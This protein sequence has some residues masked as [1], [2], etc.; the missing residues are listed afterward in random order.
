MRLQLPEK[1]VSKLLSLPESGMGYQN[2]TVTFVDG[3]FLDT[4]VMNGEFL[5][6]PD[7]VKLI[8]EIENIRVR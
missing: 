3:S 1:F 2:V 8:K 4:T 5:E 6:L 7:D